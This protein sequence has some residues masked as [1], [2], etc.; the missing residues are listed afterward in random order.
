MSFS[1]LPRVIELERRVLQPL[2]REHGFRDHLPSFQLFRELV[3]NLNLELA[4]GDARRR[5]AA[6]VF[7]KLAPRA[8]LQLH[9]LIRLEV[10]P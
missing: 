1:K 4:S 9:A 8:Q 6:K 2:R 7:G 10:R 3:S 5:L